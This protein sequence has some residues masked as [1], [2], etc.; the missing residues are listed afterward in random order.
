MRGHAFVGDKA[1]L[2]IRF[3]GQPPQHRPIV[4][5]E[6]GANLIAARVIER[7][8]ARAIYLLGREV[9]AGNQQCFR[10]CDE[11]F[12]EIGFVDGHIRAILAIEDQ[13]KRIAIFQ[14]EQHESGQALLIDTHMADVATFLAE[15]LGEK[16]AHVIVADAREHRRS[17]PEPRATESDIRRRSAEIFREARHVFEPRADLLR[18]QI[19]R[20]AAETDDIAATSRREAAGGHRDCRRRRWMCWS[21]P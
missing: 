8:A 3:A 15:R 18:V 10:R 11:R 16:A 1:G 19:D 6:H 14:S 21:D 20:E 13:R 5:I 4:D 7:A 2:A 9:R 12:V 17:K